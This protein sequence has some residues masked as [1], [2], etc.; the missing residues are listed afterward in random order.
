MRLGLIVEGHGEVSAFPILVRRLAS[1]IAPNVSLEI[2]QPLRLPKGKLRK[3][4]E[5]ARAVE[6]MA[7]KTAPDGAILIALDADDD[8][9]ARLGPELLEHVRAARSDRAV[10][11][12][13]ANREYE[14]WLIAGIAGLRG[15]RGLALNLEPPERVEEL[16]DA[17]GW[18]DTRMESGYSETIDQPRLTAL[19]DL[20][21]ARAASSFD[22]LRRDLERF[23]AAHRT[24]PSG[25]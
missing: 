16:R 7:R 18:L 10:G 17:K 8:C 24:G 2:P 12:V 6:L 14:A 25:Q 1:Q 21:R 22:K 11:V 13:V 19:F 20:E 4:G 3:Q 9:P 23:L 5:L 15:Q